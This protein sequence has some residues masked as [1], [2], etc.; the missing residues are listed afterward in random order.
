MMNEGMIYTLNRAEAEKEV[1]KIRAKL[2]PDQLDDYS[3]ISSMDLDADGQ[4]I[5]YFCILERV[6][7]I[8]NCAYSM[9]AAKAMESACYVSYLMGKAAAEKK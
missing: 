7:K 4:V 5:S 3:R 6:S 2:T 9:E 1:E 8:D